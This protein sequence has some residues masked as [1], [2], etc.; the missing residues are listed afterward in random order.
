MSGQETEEMGLVIDEKNKNSWFELPNSL[1][2]QKKKG[3]NDEEED[4]LPTTLTC[5]VEEKVGCFKK[6][7][8]CNDVL[9]LIKQDDSN[10]WYQKYPWLCEIC[11]EFHKGDRW[12]CELC[13]ADI[14]PKCAASSDALLL[15]KDESKSDDAGDG[16][17]NGRKFNQ[18]N[19]LRKIVNKSIEEDKKIT[20]FSFNVKIS[21]QNLSRCKK[22]TMHL[23]DSGLIMFPLVNYI[24]RMLQ[25]QN[26]YFDGCCYNIKSDFSVFK[27]EN[28]T[29]QD[30]TGKLDILQQNGL[31]P[32]RF[33]PKISMDQCIT[34]NGGTN[35]VEYPM[36]KIFH[37]IIIPAMVYILMAVILMSFYRFESLR[38]FNFINQYLITH[39]LYI[40]KN[41][42]S[43]ASTLVLVLVCCFAI[44]LGTLFS[45]NI[46]ELH[47]MKLELK[48]NP[49]VF[50]TFKM[51]NSS[52]EY[53]DLD[54]LGLVQFIFIEVFIYFAPLL[55][56]LWNYEKSRYLDFNLKNILLGNDEEN[57]I[58]TKPLFQ[59]DGKYAM[60]K[61]REEDLSFGRNI[62][63]YKMKPQGTLV[64]FR[65]I[66]TKST[67]E[68][69]L[70]QS[71]LQFL[72]L[73]PSQFIGMKTKSDKDFDGGIR[74]YKIPQAMEIINCNNNKN[75]K[76]CIDVPLKWI[77]GKL[78]FILITLSSL[79]FF[80]ILQLSNNGYSEEKY[81]AELL[82]N[83][84]A[85][86]SIEKHNKHLQQDYYYVFTVIFVL[87]AYFIFWMVYSNYI[88]KQYEIPSKL[89]P[90]RIKPR[91]YTSFCCN[92]C[93][94]CFLVGG[95]ILF[96]FFIPT[97]ISLSSERQD[98]V[99]HSNNV[100]GNSIGK[101]MCISQKPGTNPLQ[102][103][104]I[105]QTCD[106]HNFAQNFIHEPNTRHIRSYFHRNRCLG[107]NINSGN[108][109]FV[110]CKKKTI[111]KE[112]EYDMNV[113]DLVNIHLEWYVD[114]K[115]PYNIYLKN[116]STNSE[117]ICLGIGNNTT[118]S[119]RVSSKLC[120]EN[121][122]LP[123]WNYLACELTW[124]RFT[125]YT[126]FLLV[127]FQRIS[128]EEYFNIVKKGGV[129][130]N[131]VKEYQILQRKSSKY[132]AHYKKDTRTCAFRLEWFVYCLFVALGCCG[133]V[134]LQILNRRNPV[135]TKIAFTPCG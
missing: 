115:K 28:I 113:D 125:A 102:Q 41:A 15:K 70:V 42:R 61:I 134:L 100:D 99:I 6:K 78:I 13:K 109:S 21:A 63:N 48:N 72:S 71:D 43:N 31:Q 39:G 16:I 118:N 3:G 124:F 106:M 101:K 119:L 50:A 17:K 130:V 85:F 62:L 108:A 51:K 1:S 116:N 105:L 87:F 11:Y 12:Y 66:V 22:I 127:I 8:K 19:D 76:S 90:R 126:F 132:K 54:Y 86:E 80:G 24:Y 10:G 33:G 49:N 75:T 97:L 135:P 32:C 46:Y 93:S 88:F 111:F 35:E 68:K 23:V 121:H 112:K 103:E 52:L 110:T 73:R 82:T 7:V 38:N 122:F 96:I 26:R 133:A 74:A 104:S 27:N 77:G 117:K 81:I 65:K 94:L 29:E 92:C 58:N 83:D 129:S 128:F 131:A 107:G 40:S 45:G 47:T 98:I 95:S 114:T 123:T 5:K 44:S 18:S 60:S 79:L 91:V 89:L 69:N 30:I 36:Y 14:C 56:R 120:K 64:A 9:T 57:N 59:F 2:F 25:P 37:P 34:Y 20:V 84:N 4:I 67:E 55:L 53:T